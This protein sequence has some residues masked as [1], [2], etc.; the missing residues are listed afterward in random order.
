MGRLG[1]LAAAAVV[2]VVV[3]MLVSGWAASILGVSPDIANYTGIFSGA[4]AAGGGWKT[5]IRRLPIPG[6]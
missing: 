1:Q 2:F 3:Y 4:V 6:P 5:I